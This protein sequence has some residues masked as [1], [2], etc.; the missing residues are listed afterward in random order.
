MLSEIAFSNGQ[1]YE[2]GAKK[3]DELVGVRLALFEDNSRQ[4]MT[5]TDKKK[6]E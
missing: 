6:R 3:K 1:Y 2:R 5:R 4:I